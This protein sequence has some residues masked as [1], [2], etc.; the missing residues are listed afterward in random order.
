MEKKEEPIHKPDPGMPG[1]HG[2]EDAARR[3]PR[4]LQPEHHN[5]GTGGIRD[6][7]DSRSGHHSQEVTG[8]RDPY[9]IQ[10][11]HHD[12]DPESGRTRTLEALCL[13][14]FAGS[15]GGFVLWLL[16]GLFFPQAESIF[17]RLTDLTAVEGLTPSYFLIFSLF[18]AVSFTGVLMMWHGCQ[19]GFLL[20]AAAQTMIVAWPL[21][22]RG[23]NSFSSVS[24]I[25][26]LLFTLLYAREMWRLRKYQTS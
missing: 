6:S 4:S 11:D 21:L 1:H 12:L 15:G 14:S 17:L 20:Y 23:I 10:P 2:Q 25:F 26:S 24:L 16:C 7:V 18:S 22:M 19:S 5:A 8:R 3:N 9:G 13:L